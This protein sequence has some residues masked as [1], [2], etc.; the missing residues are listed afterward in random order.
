MT[1]IHHSLLFNGSRTPIYTSHKPARCFI[2]LHIMKRDFYL[3]RSGEER[4]SIK[5]AL[6]DGIKTREGEAL[7]V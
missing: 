5:K 6:I 7:G 1:L 3:S 4:L 2:T